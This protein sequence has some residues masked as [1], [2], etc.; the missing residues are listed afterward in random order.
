MKVNI[1]LDKD[2][3]I[4]NIITYPL[5]KSLITIDIDNLRD[6]KVGYDYFINNKIIKNE[7]YDLDM[8][9]AEINRQINEYKDKLRETDYKAL[10]Y[11]EGFIS[12][13]EYKPIK[14]ERQ[15]YRD[16]INELENN[17]LI[18]LNKK[19]L[20]LAKLNEVISKND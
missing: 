9:V 13:E 2:N 7:T 11:F 20:F 4:T 17:V 10:K 14:E 19:T 5:N 15:T 6:I 3:K 8:Q 12:E 18:I 16:K 1:T